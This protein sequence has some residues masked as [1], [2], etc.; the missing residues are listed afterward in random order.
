MTLHKWRIKYQTGFVSFFIPPD[1]CNIYKKIRCKKCKLKFFIYFHFLSRLFWRINFCTFIMQ[2][3]WEV[4]FPSFYNVVKT[5]WTFKGNDTLDGEKQA[6]ILTCNFYMQIMIGILK[7]KN[8]KWKLKEEKIYRQIWN[9]AEI[10]CGFSFFSTIINKYWNCEVKSE[11]F[12]WISTKS[13][14]NIILWWLIVK[15]NKT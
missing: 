6:L 15:Y 10:V 5:R 12:S 2:Q 7:I 13:I 14:V 8:G 3:H 1:A 9:I 4:F 11:R